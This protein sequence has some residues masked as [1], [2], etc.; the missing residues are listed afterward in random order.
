[1]RPIVLMYH[2]V[3]EVNSAESGFDT[4]GARHYKISK[5]TFLEHVKA[6]AQYCEANGLS[7]EEIIFTFDDGGLSFYTI[8]A[9]ILEEY[10]WRGIF[11]I[12]TKY[13]GTEGF[14]TSSQIVDLHQ[15]GHIIGS[16]SHHHHILTEKS[17]IEVNNELKKSAEILSNIIGE[18]IDT[19]SIPNGCYSKR[20]LDIAINEGLTTIYTSR[21]TTKVEKV[22]RDGSA[23]NV[24]ATLI[25]RYAIAY[26]TSAE[27]VMQII[28][29]PALRRKMELKYNALQLVKGVLGSNY[30]KIK[31]WIRKHLVK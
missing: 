10:G 8:I 30:S 27:D 22:K 2:D 26:N 29:Q 9:P 28:T 25:G 23:K 17:T 16:H 18:R 31:M 12:S 11:F 15:R 14:M 3:Y 19:I 20:I 24:E 5:D 4:P 13:I 7:K 1:M 21:P 6:I